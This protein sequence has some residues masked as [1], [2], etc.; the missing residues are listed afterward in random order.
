MLVLTFQAGAHRYALPAAAL[1]E[2]LP[3]VGLTPAPTLL[4][5]IAGLL[6]YRGAVA[7]VIDMNQLLLGTACP[8]L[9]SSRILLTRYP[10]PDGREGM[11]GLRVERAS[12]TQAVTAEG[13]V[14]SPVR[15]PPWLGKVVIQG[16][17]IVQLV[18]PE[19]LLG[20]R[21]RGLLFPPDRERTE[22]MIDHADPAAN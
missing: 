9:L 6:N 15:T 5:A 10:L 18:Q 16:G 14:A 7:P 2:V 20:D 11:L 12:G 8:F 4:P 21:V 1:I 13:V 3:W 22:A 17:D 19:A